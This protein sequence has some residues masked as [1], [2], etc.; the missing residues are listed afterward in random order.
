MRGFARL[1]ALFALAL[2]SAAIASEPTPFTATCDDVAGRAL[3]SDRAAL[4]KNITTEWSD[5]ETFPGPA[6]LRLAYDGRA[7]FAVDLQSRRKLPIVANAKGALIFLDAAGEGS[8]VAAWTYAVNLETHQIVA[9]QVNAF[10]AFGAG[11]KGRVMELSCKFS[12]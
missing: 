12:D 10:N 8:S 5:R 4:E 3:R 7:A 2:A 11:I 1:T 6:F 9:A